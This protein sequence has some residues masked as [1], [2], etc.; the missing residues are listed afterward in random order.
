VDAEQMRISRITKLG[1]RVGELVVGLEV[2]LKNNQG[3]N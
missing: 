1:E 2:A 3:S